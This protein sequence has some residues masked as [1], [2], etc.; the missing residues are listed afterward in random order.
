M[1]KTTVREVFIVQIAVGPS[2]TSVGRSGE[3]FGL[4]DDGRVY[5]YD[6]RTETWL[7]YSKQIGVWPR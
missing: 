2:T 6:Y 3:L 1:A 4:G 5:R 7:K